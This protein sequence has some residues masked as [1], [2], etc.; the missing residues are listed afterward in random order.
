MKDLGYFKLSN[1]HDYLEGSFIEDRQAILLFKCYSDVNNCIKHYQESISEL[2]SL[3][4]AYLEIQEAETDHGNGFVLAV[5]KRADEADILRKRKKA[6]EEE[7]EYINKK[8]EE[9]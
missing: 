5:L 4:D 7:M 6:I 2:L 8:L 9:L 1:I 3:K